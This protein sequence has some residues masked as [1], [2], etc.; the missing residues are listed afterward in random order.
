MH[1]KALHSNR[2]NIVQSKQHCPKPNFA[3]VAF[4][5]C[6]KAHGGTK[7]ICS[8]TFLAL[9]NNP[10]KSDSTIS[11]WWFGTFYI[12]PYIGNVIIPT[13]ELIFFRGVGQP[14]TSLPC[15]GCRVRWSSDLYHFAGGP[16]WS[17]CWSPR[18]SPWCLFPMAQNV[19]GFNHLQ[20][21]SYMYIC[22]YVCVCN[23]MSNA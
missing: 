13:D 9:F 11:G 7:H 12:F 1:T 8:E 17:Q 23:Y 6:R 21:I 22:V 3:W 5:S 16:C 4:P 20:Y 19:G 2:T 10:S 18:F 14:P 15:Q